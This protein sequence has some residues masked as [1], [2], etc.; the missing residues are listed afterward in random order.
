MIKYVTKYALTVGIIAWEGELTKDGQYFIGRTP[1]NGRFFISVKEC[2][3]CPNDAALDA[4][5]RKQKKIKSLNKQLQKI[6]KLSFTYQSDK[7][8]K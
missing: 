7:E 5:V 6:E 8:V 1:A 3:D 2:F 4:N